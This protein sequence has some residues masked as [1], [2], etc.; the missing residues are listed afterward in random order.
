MKKHILFFLFLLFS[1]SVFA[2]KDRDPGT[3][4][5]EIQFLRTGVEGT[6]LFK[7][8]TYCKKEKDCFDFAKVDAIKAIIF[9]GIPGSG[10][11]RPMIPE[12]GAEDKYRDYFIEFFKPGGKYLNFVAISNDGSISED[13]RFKVGKNLKIGIIISVQKANLRRELEAAGIVK[14]LSAGF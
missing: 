1:V 8:F 2:Q 12:A 5:Y 13:D 3:Y 6:E 11:Q 10:L 7:I 4:N 9:K 14:P